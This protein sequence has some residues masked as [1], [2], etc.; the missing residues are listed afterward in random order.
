MVY[1]IATKDCE[2]S[3][4]NLALLERYLYKL[5]DRISKF[6]TDLPLLYF[7]LRWQSK[8]DYYYG[9]I[10]LDLPKKRLYVN[11]QGKSI[12]EA[13]QLGFERI[14]KEVETY[15]GLH[16]T[17]DSEYYDHTNLE[18][19]LSKILSKRNRSI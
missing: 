13:I 4:K 16:F 3:E 17:S 14:K 6:S 12:E 15:K 19:I 9:S 18:E 7:V 2:I 1:S 11:F 10:Y 5:S 8:K